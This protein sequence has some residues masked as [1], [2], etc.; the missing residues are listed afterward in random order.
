MNKELAII[1][2][3]FKQVC[4]LFK[5]YKNKPFDAFEPE[6][7]FVAKKGRKYRATMAMVASSALL[8]MHQLPQY[9]S[10]L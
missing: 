5:G 9:I 10:Y 8:I 2:K 7:Y 4:T 3:L 1:T 6:G